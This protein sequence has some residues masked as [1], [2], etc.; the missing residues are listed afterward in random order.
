M[1][2]TRFRADLVVGRK[3][4][5]ARGRVVGTLRELRIEV[6]APGARDYVVREVE[7]S[8]PWW[9]ERLVGPQFATILAR[10]TNRK[11]HRFTVRWE[12]IDLTDPRKPRLRD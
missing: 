1:R 2:G 7:L 12:K 6:A 3:V 9:V 8:A 5:D 11:P 4:R 10:W